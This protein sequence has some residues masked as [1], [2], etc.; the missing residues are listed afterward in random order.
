MPSIAIDMSNI[1][2]AIAAELYAANASHI[3]FLCRTEIK[4]EH[5]KTHSYIHDG[6]ST[7]D[8]IESL[9]DA[10]D[11]V[12]DRLY[13]SYQESQL[14]AEIPGKQSRRVVLTRAV[15]LVIG[16][17][18]NAIPINK[19][20]GNLIVSKYALRRVCSV[21]H[22]MRYVASHLVSRP[23]AQVRATLVRLLLSA[24][25]KHSV[26]RIY[27]KTVSRATE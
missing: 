26:P 15:S 24:F 23:R 16:R 19:F 1:N 14:F 3:N 6:T 11:F 22:P 12:F 20:G 10:L 4:D 5:G 2:D 27:S 8:D 21:M 9:D 7:R 17:V 18:G 13:T 25:K